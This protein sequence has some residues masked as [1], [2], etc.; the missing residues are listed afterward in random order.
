M[1]F[2][3][4]LICMIVTFQASASTYCRAKATTVKKIEQLR[5][6]DLPY[7][8]V[9]AQVFQSLGSDKC[10][11]SRLSSD[12]IKVLTQMLLN[13]ENTQDSA[14]QIIGEFLAQ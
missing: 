13:P 8:V 11:K 3:I 14:G 9:Q 4:A 5:M 2:L 10:V 7:K 12:E 1:K 6:V